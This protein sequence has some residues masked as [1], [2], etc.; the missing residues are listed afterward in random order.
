MFVSITFMYCANF[1]TGISMCISEETPL[2]NVLNGKI[3]LF[4]TSLKCS[5]MYLFIVSCVLHLFTHWLVSSV[6][7]ISFGEVVEEHF[8][9][10][11][12]PKVVIN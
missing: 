1:I 10:R 9:K 12:R 3:T 11:I 8:G 2:S 7:L 4:V 6:L 5:L